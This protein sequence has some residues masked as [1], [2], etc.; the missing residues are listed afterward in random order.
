MSIAAPSA[1]LLYG[2]SNLCYTAYKIGKK[3]LLQLPGID[4]NKEGENPWRHAHLAG[5]T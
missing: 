5:M 2:N 4:R 3:E 1:L